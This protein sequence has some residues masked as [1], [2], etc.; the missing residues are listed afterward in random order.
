MKYSSSFLPLGAIAALSLCLPIPAPAQSKSASPSPSASASP[1]AEKGES[2]ATKPARAIPLRGTVS[3]VDA[4][5]KTFTITSK[6]GGTRVFKVTDKTTITKDGEEATFADIEAEGKIS[7]SYWKQDDGTL[8]V[9]SVK[10]GGAGATEKAK[11]KKRK[12]K[13]AAADE[14]AEEAD[15][16]ASPSPSSE[17]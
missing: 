3:E 6:K 5:A 12:S 15:E 4:D 13:K 16:S 2:T 14:G 8:E 7:G 11:K 10:I 9:K 1:A 17:E